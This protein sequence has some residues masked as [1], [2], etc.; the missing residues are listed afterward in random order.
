MMTYNFGNLLR[1]PGRTEKS[2]EE[3]DILDLPQVYVDRYGIRLMEFQYAHLPFQEP[4]ML[5]QLQARMQR[6]GVRISQI[7]LELNGIAISTSETAARQQAVTLTMQAIDRCDA[8]GC[9][10]LM[11]NQGKLTRDRMET[12]GDALKRIVDYAEQKKISICMEDRA[13][14]QT[15]RDVIVNPVTYPPAVLPPEPRWVNNN[16]TRVAWKS[17]FPFVMAPEPPRS[18]KPSGRE[19]APD[20]EN[21]LLMELYK[22]TKA[23]ANIDVGGMCVDTQQAMDDGIHVMMPYT[24]GQVH[25]NWRD[26]PGWD[27]P[28]TLHTFRDTGFKGLYVIEARP[29]GDSYTIAEGLK[30]V[31]LANI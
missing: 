11:I 21:T 1:Y 16:A 30:E 4:V 20:A 24:S 10:R 17:G 8:L 18:Y 31:I 23:Y 13:R 29:L 2:S 26:N 22:R 28:A 15:G 27:L 7:N 5:S 3:L 9:P 14:A 12:A 25:I 19:W 6:A